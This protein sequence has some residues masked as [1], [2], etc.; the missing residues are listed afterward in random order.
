MTMNRACP[1]CGTDLFE[2]DDPYLQEWR[3]GWLEVVQDPPELVPYS[4]QQ[5]P[6]NWDG[7]EDARYGGLWFCS[8]QCRDEYQEQEES[9]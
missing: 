8:E 4:E 1:T 7:P 5:R 3:D 9:V 2:M 6:E